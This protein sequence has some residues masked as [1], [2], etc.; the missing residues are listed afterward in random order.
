[1][2]NASSKEMVILKVKDAGV[3]IDK[4]IFQKLFTKFTTDS[5]KGMGLGLYISKKIIV[6]HDGD[7]WAENNKDDT[8]AT[9][10]FTLPLNK[11]G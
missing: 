2:P 6:A 7:L 8:G 9:F 3:G 10:T 5:Y 11:A 1:M 4:E